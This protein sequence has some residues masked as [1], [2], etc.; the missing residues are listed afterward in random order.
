[1]IKELTQS[2]IFWSIIGALGGGVLSFLFGLFMER[3]KRRR[4]ELEY[5]I[6]YQKIG[7]PNEYNMSRDFQITY[8]NRP[9]ENLYLF[10]LNVKNNSNFD[11]EKIPLNFYCDANSVIYSYSV[12]YRPITTDL[13]SSPE[14]ERLFSEH[15]ER[16]N[17]ILEENP[18]AII[19]EP[20]LSQGLWFYRNRQLIAS[21]INRKDNIEFNILIGS[22]V[23]DHLPILFLDVPKSGVLIKYAKDP[24]KENDRVGKISI[25]IGILLTF[26]IGIY[27]IY[28]NKDYKFQIIILSLIGALNFFIGYFIFRF[29]DF[30]YKYF[31]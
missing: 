2:T 10:S 15:N 25:S 4:L 24:T 28:I 18:N 21:A 17:P 27:L 22:Q 30:F 31:K 23:K 1:M 3:Y 12:G 29:F 11:G 7:I 19:S 5:N 14:Y 13:L 6:T 8:F 16:V 26:I 20:L 9:V